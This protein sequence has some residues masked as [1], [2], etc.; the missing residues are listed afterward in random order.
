MSRTPHHAKPRQEDASISKFRIES[1]R[2]S[3][4]AQDSPLAL[5]APKHYEPNYAYPLLVWLHTPGA[6][7]R[8]LVRIMPTI[9]LRNYVAVAPRGFPREQSAGPGHHWP[10]TAD[11]IAAAAERVSQAV[12]AT[13]RKYHVAERR[14]FL[15]GFG[16]G[17][18][19]ALRIALNEPDRFAGVL[20]LCGAFPMGYAPLRCL[21]RA[22]DVPVFLAVGRDSAGYSPAR[23]CD[24]LRLF[25]TA[26]VSVTMH[27]YPCGHELT[28]RMLRDVDRWIIEQI[29]TA[30]KASSEADLW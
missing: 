27:Q 8:Q 15:A 21:T 9:S 28:S 26:G 23:A 17:G 11:H 10:Q 1:G 3:A 24:D 7:E 29:T 4:A 14:I 5:F 30:A 19:M 16:S 12:D 6:D 25:H 18:S 22:R 2:F 13:R 20:S